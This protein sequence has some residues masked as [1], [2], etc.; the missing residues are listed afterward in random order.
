MG[1]SRWS[2]PRLTQ[3]QAERINTDPPTATLAAPA[4]IAMVRN[5]VYT[6]PLWSPR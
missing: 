6:G 1:T 5:T 3:R 2:T 4:S